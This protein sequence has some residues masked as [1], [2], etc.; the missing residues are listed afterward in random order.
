MI[1]TATSST[2]YWKE[3]GCYDLRA[4]RTPKEELELNWTLFHAI[5]CKKQVPIV[6]LK[7]MKIGVIRTT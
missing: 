1:V 7:L 4:G 5:I 2:A 3:M 6:L